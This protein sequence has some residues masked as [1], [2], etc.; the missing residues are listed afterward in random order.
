MCHE[1]NIFLK[2][3]DTEF[4]QNVVKP[5]I[6]NKVEKTFVDLCLLEDVKAV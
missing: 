2:L 3:Q 6:S 4:F 1:L 5:F